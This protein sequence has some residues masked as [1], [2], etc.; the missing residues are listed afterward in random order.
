M[1]KQA[2][3][4]V[5]QMLE[6]KIGNKILVVTENDLGFEG[7]L[8]TVSNKPPGLWLCKAEVVTL[9]STV[10][11]PLPSIVNR[12][13]KNELFIHLNTVQRVEVI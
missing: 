7:I 8:S 1:S 6:K 9:R 12:A 11:N 10:V 5:F 3:P 4:T 2:K 13:D